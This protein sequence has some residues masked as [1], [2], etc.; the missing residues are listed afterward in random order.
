M[1][2]VSADFY[3]GTIF[4][5]LENMLT[6]YGVACIPQSYEV[7]KEAKKIIAI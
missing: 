4:E 6:E 7:I 3:D 2:S 1:G 5:K